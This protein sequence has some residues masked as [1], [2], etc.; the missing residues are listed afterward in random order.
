MCGRYTYLFQWKQLHRLMRL[1]EWPAEELTPRYNVKPTQPAPVV[2]LNAGGQRI[3]SM[4]EWGLVPSW[5]KSPAGGDMGKHINARSESVFDKPTFRTAAKERR[6]LV[7]VSGFY[8]WQAVLGSR[9]RQ[10]YWIARTDREPFCFAGLWESWRDRNAPDSEPPLET[11][12]ILTTSPNSLMAPIHDRMPVIVGPSDWEAWL[13]PST[14][15]ATLAG[16]LHP[17]PQHDLEA[18]PVGR[19]VS[20]SDR[21]DSSLIEPVSPPPAAPGLFG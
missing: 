20:T 3:G 7:P 12:A 13:D 11:F 5:S 21:D 8:E 10:P 6:C 16:L 14:P 4:M 18:I 2:R 9:V 15:Q 19:Q 1:L 17:Y